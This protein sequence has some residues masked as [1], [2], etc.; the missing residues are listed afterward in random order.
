MLEL[1]KILVILGVDITGYISA[2]FNAYGTKNTYGTKKF[3]QCKISTAN[4]IKNNIFI[5]NPCAV[6]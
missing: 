3:L 1:N 5:R 6:A 4:V 2:G